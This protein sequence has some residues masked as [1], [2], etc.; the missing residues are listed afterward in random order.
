MNRIPKIRFLTETTINIKVIKVVC[1]L[2]LFTSVNF[3][4]GRKVRQNLKTYNATKNKNDKKTSCNDPDLITIEVT[5]C[6]SVGISKASIA[7]VFIVSDVKFSGYDK[8]ATANKESIHVINGT[9][10]TLKSI[11]IK[12]IYKD[13]QGRMLHSRDVVLKCDIPPAETRKIDFSTWDKQHSFYY[14]LSNAPK[15]VASP[16]KIEIIPH[17]FTISLQRK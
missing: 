14:Y 15:R 9:P 1:L 16:Y 2:L 10:Y 4:E 8:H 11:N 6:D 7:E 17:S 3:A 13:M 5:S 12:I